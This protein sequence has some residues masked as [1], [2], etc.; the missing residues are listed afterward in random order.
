MSQ[1]VF[2]KLALDLKVQ[3]LEHWERRRMIT[4]AHLKVYRNQAPNSKNAQ[5]QRRPLG[6]S[7]NQAKKD[8]KQ[9]RYLL[10]KSHE[11]LTP[12]AMEARTRSDIQTNREALFPRRRTISLWRLCRR[13]LL[14]GRRLTRRK[15]QTLFESIKYSNCRKQILWWNQLLDLKRRVNHRR[16][17]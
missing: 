14:E 1:R 9:M 5:I 12:P 16:N 4:K 11:W 10:L 3:P 8:S 7:M 6:N 2:W 15:Q 13:C 17:R